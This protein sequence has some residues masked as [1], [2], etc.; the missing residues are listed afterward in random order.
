[1]RASARRTVTVRR[2][3]RERVVLRDVV[4]DGTPAHRDIEPPG[5]RLVKAAHLTH[6]AHRAAPDRVGAGGRTAGRVPSQRLWLP[7][8]GREQDHRG[9]VEAG[10]REGGRWH[11]VGLRVDGGDLNL[12]RESRRQLRRDHRACRTRHVL[13]RASR[14][15]RH[16]GDRVGQR[17]RVRAAL[18]LRAS[19]RR[20]RRVAG[21]WGE[22]VR[23]HEPFAARRDVAIHTRSPEPFC[24][25]GRRRRDVG[26]GGRLVAEVGAP[27]VGRRGR[28]GRRSDV[29]VAAR[30]CEPNLSLTQVVALQPHLTILVARRRN[31]RSVDDVEPER[32]RVQPV[33]RGGWEVVFVDAESGA[34]ELDQRHREAEAQRLDVHLHRLAH[35]LDRHTAN[36]PTEVEVV[37]HGRRRPRRVRHQHFDRYRRRPEQSMH[38]GA[39]GPGGSPP[40]A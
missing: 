39:H 38:R 12:R 35:R 37:P 17:G 27:R 21:R 7:V 1:M 23:K 20:R 30:E 31:L 25:G 40:P 19:L 33:A 22:V 11:S 32:R 24:G 6:A 16:R 26:C 28:R 10:R 5:L 9:R 2:S 18:L 8:T 13:R 4:A 34:E 29:L 15:A 36:H 14:R 3:E